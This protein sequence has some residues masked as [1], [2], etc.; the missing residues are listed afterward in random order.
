L[1]DRSDRRS[2]LAVVA[3]WAGALVAAAPLGDFPINDD[4]SW[5][6]AVRALTLEHT[7]RL[8][9]FTGMPL[10]TQ[11][12]WGSLFA[13]AGGFSFNTLRVSTL[14]LALL[15]VVG[16][17]R[18]VRVCGGSRYL[19]GLGALALAIC[20]LFFALSVT[21]MTDVPFLTL[22]IWS[23]VAA[24]RYQQT[25]ELRTVTALVALLVAAALLRQLGAALAIALAA[26]L[27]VTTRR[28]RVT[29]L[30]AIVPAAALALYYRMIAVIGAP[31]F[32]QT[33]NRAV[34]ST[35][36]H[37]SGRLAL[38]TAVRALETW[39]YVGVLLI[40]ALAAIPLRRVRTRALLFMPAAIV[41]VA[42]LLRTRRDIRTFS[43]IL[44]D[45]GL[46]PVVIARRDLW[47]AAPRAFWIALSAAGIVAAATATLVI[48][49]ALLGWIRSGG[50]SG[51]P[52]A[53]LIVLFAC[54]ALWMPL[55]FVR[56]F[57]RYFLPP[58]LFVF[59]MV[60]M[61]IG[62]SAVEAPRGTQAAMAIAILCSVWVFDVAAIRDCF[63][64]HRARW[65]AVR[66]AQASGVA[67][68]DIDGGFE[69]NGLLSYTPSERV[70]GD[71]AWYLPKT[72]P[73]ALVSLGPVDGYV[74]ERIY[75]FRRWLP[76][77]SGEVWLLRREPR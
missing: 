75:S 15:A 48:A 35:L 25:R 8:T 7:W 58:S 37:P 41:P 73:S 50:L 21:F 1:F 3:I 39:T 4:W 49:R 2:L 57:D 34:A 72:R 12:I 16:A 71:E 11:I 68:R 10:A 28:I 64:F 76:P 19:A 45:I 14:V 62:R 36:L 20:P 43:S 18:L 27:A 54:T 23:S 40:P 26:A 70:H 69:V 6:L 31:F 5:A 77:G 44:W 32:F 13:Q 42:V 33:N 61:A 67:D 53:F 24:I 63:A 46:N 66:D 29:A 55:W 74:R 30:V 60:A 38:V 22:A 51:V 56:D 17:Y 47:P 59:V 9:D 65:A 52:P